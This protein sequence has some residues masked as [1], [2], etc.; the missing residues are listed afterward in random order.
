[1][2]RKSVFLTS[3]LLFVINVFILVV[4]ETVAQYLRDCVCIVLRDFACSIRVA[5]QLRVSLRALR[6]GKVT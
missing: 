4:S 1:M 5:K 3:V 2:N 6:L